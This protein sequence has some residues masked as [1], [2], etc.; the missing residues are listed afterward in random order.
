MTAQCLA[1][2]C[3]WTILIL[4]RFPFTTVMWCHLQTAMFL[5]P[6]RQCLGQLHASGGSLHRK[7]FLAQQPGAER[8]DSL[9]YICS[10]S[11]DQLRRGPR[12]I[13]QC[14]IHMSWFSYALLQL[15]FYLVFT[16]CILLQTNLLFWVRVCMVYM[17]DILFFGNITTLFKCQ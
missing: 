7:C 17:Y 1:I 15:W 11:R 13:C 14:F 16:I 9:N 2:L 10:L 5:G 6:C 4:S 8:S 12:S 3:L